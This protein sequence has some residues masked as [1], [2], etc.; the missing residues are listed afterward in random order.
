M[1]PERSANPYLSYGR[2][3]SCAM[4][5]TI[6]AGNSRLTVEEN[7]SSNGNGGNRF[8]GN[9]RNAT[10]SVTEQA[11]SLF[12]EGGGRPISID[13]GG[14]YGGGQKSGP[15]EIRVLYSGRHEGLAFYFAR[16][17]RPIWRNKI[18]V[19]VCVYSHLAS[20]ADSTADRRS[21]T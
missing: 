21:R 19:V 3:Q 14:S 13:R 5:L 17:V 20:C 15:E 1:A 10:S 4:L 18:T 6:A 7:S 11:K 12:F 16:L 2:D 9:T 8:A